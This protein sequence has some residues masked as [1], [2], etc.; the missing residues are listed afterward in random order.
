MHRS[1]MVVLAG[2]LLLGACS[3]DGGAE[4][5]TIPLPP[6]VTD[7][8]TPSTA[9]PT[10]PTAPPTDPP[11]TPTEATQTS[12]P[13]TETI[14]TTMTERALRAK[15]AADYERSEALL[16]EL[17]MS[18]TTKGLDARL[19]EIAAPRSQAF[20]GVK[21]FISGMVERGERVVNNDPDHSTLDVEKVELKGE[22][23][24]REAVVTFCWVNNQVRIDGAGN[25]Q[26]GT[27][28]LV[29]TRSEDSVVLT[30]NG[31]WLPSGTIVDIWQGLEEV[32]CPPT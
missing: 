15:I 5:A 19:A 17:A 29:A 18:P 28:N 11:T 7:P 24:Y 20:R 13:T 2:V 12:P 26:G 9:D 25:P 10:D 22:R 21:E 4:P 23:P 14:P 16:E 3:D 27:G 31:R 8:T 6:G 1:S 32:E 30:A